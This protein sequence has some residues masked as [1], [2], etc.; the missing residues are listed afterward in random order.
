M[1]RKPILKSHGLAIQSFRT[2]LMYGHIETI[3]KSDH[4]SGIFTVQAHATLPSVI[5]LMKSCSIKIEN[6][7]VAVQ[8]RHFQIIKPPRG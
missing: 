5:M 3:T 7:Q 2:V 4:F 1:T 8:L 6:R